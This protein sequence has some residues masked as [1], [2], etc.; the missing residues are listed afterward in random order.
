[1]EIKEKNRRQKIAIIV[2]MLAVITMSIGLYFSLQRNDNTSKTAV[3]VQSSEKLND[4][5]SGQLR[6]RINSAVQ[7]YGETMQDLAFSN[8][9]KDR[10]LQCKIKVGDTY[11][12]DSGLV[13]SGDIVQ[14]DVVDTSVLQKGKNPATAEIYN[15]N[16]EH[17]LIGQTNTMIEL[18]LND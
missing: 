12:Y 11:V 15:Y 6:I 16:M 4:M 2:L 7:I 5:R 13:K 18:Y 9:N 1:M 10:Q 3:I 8:L 17:A 14:A